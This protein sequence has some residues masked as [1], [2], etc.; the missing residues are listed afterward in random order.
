L[1]QLADLGDEQVG[2]LGFRHNRKFRY[3]AGQL[4]TRSGFVERIE[5]K[6]R[7]KLEASFPFDIGLKN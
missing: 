7:L 2:S 3:C 4:E 6:K 5:I 1:P